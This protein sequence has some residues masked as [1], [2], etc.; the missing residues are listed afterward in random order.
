M[1][2]KFLLGTQGPR[3]RPR[4]V[5]IPFVAHVVR[6]RWRSFGGRRAVG[7]GR[8]RVIEPPGFDC[9]ARTCLGHG[10]R[11]KVQL[12]RP[13]RCPDSGD[14]VFYGRVALYTTPPRVEDQRSTASQPVVRKRLPGDRPPR[15]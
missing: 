1:S 12:T 10:S 7:F 6:I 4:K 11:F 13:S 14:L 3:T 9:T 5:T 15:R 8:M 2:G